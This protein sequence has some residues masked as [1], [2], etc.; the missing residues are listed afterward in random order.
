MTGIF[1]C[2]R[3]DD[4]KPWVLLLREELAE[5]F[6]E[7]HVF[8]DKDTLHVGNWREQIQ[9]ALDQ[10]EIVL[11]VMGQRW[12]TI[13]DESGQ[14][15]LD[16]ADDVHR[17]E[18]ALALS[19]RSVT[20]I[21]VRVDAATMPRAEDLPE[22]IRSLTD[23]QSRELSDSSARREVDLKLLIAD[24]ERVSRLKA[25]KG[26]PRKD[27][28]ASSANASPKRWLGLSAKALFAALVASIAVLVSAEIALGW[29][30]GPPEISL[31]VLI[32]LGLTIFGARLRARWKAKNTNART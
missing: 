18:I 28:S 21:P 32:V 23:Q 9:Q 27:A 15:R 19:R 13:T 3:Q 24:I 30:F 4:A 17:Q 2:Y 11:I 1:I 25:G 20:V 22:D 16:R 26:L 8:L 14:R 29:T 31:I 5:A 10:C 12:L 7:E 6:G